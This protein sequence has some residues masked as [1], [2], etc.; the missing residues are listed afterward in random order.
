MH[1]LTTFDLIVPQVRKVIPYGKVQ[2][3]GTPAPGV[4]P[5]VAFHPLENQVDCVKLGDF[6]G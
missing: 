3:P 4:R 1:I 6:I 5:L 2:M